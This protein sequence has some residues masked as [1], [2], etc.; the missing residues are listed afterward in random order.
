[1]ENKPWLKHYPPQIPHTLTY[2]ETSLQQLLKNTA[3]KYPNKIAI[4]FNGKELS[5]KELYESALKFADTCRKLVFKKGIGW[6]L[7]CQTL[8]NP[9]LVF[10]GL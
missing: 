5:Y 1:M 3:E 8:H 2:E 6:R 10:M 4:H 9:S 7:C